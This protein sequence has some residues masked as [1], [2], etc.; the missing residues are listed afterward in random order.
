TNVDNNLVGKESSPDEIPTTEEDEEFRL[1]IEEKLTNQDIAFAINTM[2]KEA[3]H[4]GISIRQLFYGM[5]STF[6]KNP[7]PHNVN[8]KDPGAGKSYL[9]NLVASYFPEKYVIALAGMSDKAI[10]HRNG[11]M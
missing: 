8:S 11:I 1:A 6:S 10:L 2:K 5:A 4:D 3:P 7:I 9:L